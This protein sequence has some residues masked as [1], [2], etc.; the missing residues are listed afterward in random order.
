MPNNLSHLRV[1]LVMGEVGR[2]YATHAMMILCRDVELE[3]KATPVKS[4]SLGNDLSFRP[5]RS[6]YRKVGP[7]GDVQLNGKRNTTLL[8]LPGSDITPS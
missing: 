1:M 4:P 3:V 6:W 8:L 2:S 5:R 7:C